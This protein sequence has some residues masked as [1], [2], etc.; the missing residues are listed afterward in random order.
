M[1][2]LDFSGEADANGIDGA[3]DVN[4]NVEEVLS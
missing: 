1:K 3:N 4:I 2:N